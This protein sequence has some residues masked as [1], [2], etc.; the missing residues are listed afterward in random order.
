M[1]LGLI[2]KFEKDI[3]SLKNPALDLKGGAEN[4]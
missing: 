2:L 1:R 3:A 4:F